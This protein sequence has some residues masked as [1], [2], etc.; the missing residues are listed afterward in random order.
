MLGESACF[1]R[2]F[3][4]DHSW[5]KGF[6]VHRLRHTFATRWLES[7]RS[8][9]ALKEILG[10]STIRLTERY[11]RLSRLAV[12]AEAMKAPEVEHRTEQCPARRL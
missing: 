1:L 8:I 6:H 2:R 9:E 11:G 12:A 5:V 7:K 3:V 10:H 4:A